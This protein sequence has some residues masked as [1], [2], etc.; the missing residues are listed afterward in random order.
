MTP[1]TDCSPPGST[2]HG[3]SQATTWS[4]L[5]F[6]SPEGLTDP[7][8]KLVSPALADRFFTTESPGKS[9]FIHLLKD[10]Y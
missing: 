10:I 4:G 3:V 2:V 9:P 5:S 1:W 6:P 8:I 7:G